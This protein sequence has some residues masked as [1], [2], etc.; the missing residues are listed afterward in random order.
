MQTKQ[1]LAYGAGFLDEDYRARLRQC[2]FTLKQ[3]AH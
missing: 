2:G 1:S 3:G